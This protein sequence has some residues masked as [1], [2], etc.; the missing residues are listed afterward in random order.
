MCKYWTENINPGSIENKKLFIAEFAKICKPN[1]A[2]VI[3]GGEATLDMDE[4]VELAA[5]AKANNLRTAININ[6]TTIK[7]DQVAKRLMGVMTEVIVSIDSHIPEVH[8]GLRGVSGVHKL[9]VSAVNK[10]ITAKTD[11]QKIGIM[12]VLSEQN[13]RE[14]DNLCDFAFN[15]L[16]IN[17]FYP[18]MLQPTFNGKGVDRWF[19]DNLIKDPDDF[20]KIITDCNIKYNLGLEQYIKD[21]K[22]YLESLWNQSPIMGWNVGF[23]TREHIC[24]SYERN[25]IIDENDVAWLCFN[26]YLGP[27]RRLEPGQLKDFCD[28]VKDGMHRSCNR[29]CGI[30]HCVTRSCRG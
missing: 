28:N 7:N 17:G 18:N 14:L 5:A 30:S 4:V 20:E 2:V 19:A 26:T 22:M 23:G 24:D 13:Y 3:T 8:D 29:I 6:G 9:A 10:L 11:N 15:L 21:A 27:G 16:K 12:S 1:A 25:V